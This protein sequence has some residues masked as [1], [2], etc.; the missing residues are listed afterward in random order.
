MADAA[1][2]AV[3][4]VPLEADLVTELAC[5]LIARYRDDPLALADVLI[6]LPN[7]RARTALTEAFVREANGGMLLPR[8]VAVGDIELDETLA[9]FVDPLEIAGQPAIAPTI[10]DWERRF[11]L[12][13][14]IRKQ[15]PQ[16]SAVEA[17][18][19]AASLAQ[20]I[21]QLDIE[22]IAPSAINNEHLEGE[23]AAHW[24]TAYLDFLELLAAHNREVAKRG[25]LGPSARRNVLLDRLS[26]CL[27]T[28]LHGRTVIAAGISTA[29]PAVAKLLKQVARLPKGQVILP[30]VDLL[31]ET[32]DWDA[33]GPHQRTD[34]AFAKRN[35][36][37]HPQYQLKLLL[38]RMG[39][40]REELS[41]FGRP[42]KGRGG[43]LNQSIS[44]IFGSAKQS[45]HWGDLP[46]AI[47][48]L[49]HVRALEADTVA[50][51]ALAIA[52]LIRGAIET[53]E[54]RV[55]LITADRELA[56]RTATQLQRWGI[57]VDD[58]AGLPLKHSLPA[59]LLLAL[60]DA[61]ADKFG[62]VS[63]LALL[64]HPLVE[65]GDDRL[66]WLAQVR[67]LDIAL[68]GPRLGIG[69]AGIAETI[70]RLIDAQKEG[71]KKKAYEA[72]LIWWNGV[73]DRMR[74][75][76]TMAFANLKSILNGCAEI[77]DNLTGSSVWK[78]EAGRQLANLI[79][80]IGQQDASAFHDLEAGSLP[81]LFARLLDGEVV[82]PAYGRH[83]R[84]AIW[85]LL[86]ARMQHADM[87]ICGG[88][89][90]G[91]WPQHAQPDPWLAPRLRAEL[92]LQGLD[93][94][95][96]LAAHDL[97][98]ALGAQ[99]VVLTRAKRD[100]SG[101]TIASRFW[102]R[103]EA[104]LGKNL[105]R[106]EAALAWVK[107]IDEGDKIE[108]A[109]R[110]SI[111][112][113]S[114]QRKV[115]LSVTQV[116]RLKADPFAFY[117]EK[118]L[119]LRALRSP[120]TEP[121]HAWRGTAI[122]DLLEQWAKLDNCANG[123]LLLR[124]DALFSTPAMNP[125]LKTLWQPRIRRAL[126]WTEEEMQRQSEAGRVMLFAEEFGD[127]KLAG[128]RLSGK[129]DRIDRLSDGSLAI[130]DYKTGKPPSSSKIAA[131]FAPQLGLLGLIAK[132][133]GFKQGGG[134]AS[135]FEYW[136]MSKD[137]GEFGAVKS[138]L[139]KKEIGSE[140]SM[141]FIDAAEANATGVIEQW[142][143]GTEPFTAKL[144]PDYAVGEDYDQLMRLDEWY[145]RQEPDH[146]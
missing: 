74:G 52:I 7:N 117:A 97:A 90:E 115:D 82:R 80:Q 73:A 21:D 108:P 94:N 146:G 110:P 67:K 6:L 54:K 69:L 26:D 87:V 124:A 45:Q 35:E 77:A 145:G 33:L 36:E 104:L 13:S 93:R 103:I 111:N 32:A 46:P 134:V 34:Q 132:R 1:R 125:V 31:M 102:M 41:A 140:G 109:P 81:A 30:F 3:F 47:K 40:R 59:T 63:L 141:K 44:A 22:E 139:P 14:L 37:T 18:R 57:E 55:A 51:E 98:S 133:G 121:D 92:D 27:S 144:H 9:T 15:R 142:I 118:I 99:E 101:P 105:Q 42:K 10:A 84:I 5:D 20:T 53:P 60:V 114:E 83:P 19:L 116:E 135:R 4:T 136:T 113:S 24:N 85:G 79:E 29:A 107:A 71:D 61:L 8:M 28:Q 39:A 122:H 123:A 58:S 137:G 56:V 88:L 62:P 78:G 64:K 120:G 2:P 95:I 43:A 12:T 66:A 126:A 50:E 96:G 100:R 68:R 38:D 138:A 128:V 86:E 70:Q 131:G 16:L 119:K 17:L 11:L 106:E 127:L 49:P 76:E 65:T 143:L 91:Q 48:K 75:F 130:V 89:N 25:T 129:V 112:P 23:L 72:L